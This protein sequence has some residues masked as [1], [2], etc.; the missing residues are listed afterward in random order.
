MGLFSLSSPSSGEA[1]GSYIPKGF[2]LPREHIRDCTSIK[3][4]VTG[5]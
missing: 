4:D 5:P 2:G 3:I 1:A